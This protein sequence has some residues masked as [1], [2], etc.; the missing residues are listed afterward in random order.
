MLIPETRVRF[1]VATH[2][3]T[4][5]NLLVFSLAP[6]SNSNPATLVAEDGLEDRVG[7]QALRRRI[8]N[9]KPEKRQKLC[10]ASRWYR[11]SLAV[12]TQKANS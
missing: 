2:L 10:G 6:D 5:L 8:V 3:L 9:Q 11:A 7:R 4:S 12:M 1:P